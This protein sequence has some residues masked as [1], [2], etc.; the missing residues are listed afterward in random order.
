M[1][2]FAISDIHGCKKTFKALLKKIKLTPTDTLFLLGDYI[3]RGP[4]SRGVIKY[5]LKLKKKG[6]KVHCLR[7]NH[8]QM[9]I[10]ALYGGS[11]EE[12]TQWMLSG[13]AATLKSYY[14]GNRRYVRQKHLTF[15]KK[16]PY[17]IETEGYILVHAGLEFRSPNP[18]ANQRRM[19]WIRS[20]YNNIDMAWLNGRIIV[21]GH[22]PVTQDSIKSSLN[23]LETRPVVDIDCGCVY[24][25]KGMNQ[26][27]AFNLDTQ[28]LIFQENIEKR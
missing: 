10:D 12:Q 15:I 16:L 6:Y 14:K 5:I 20:W 7:G 13:G 3:D 22:T 19:I 1:S 25:R 27:C 4:N 18:F 9:M 8:E 11:E 23:Y 24:T 26:L 17:Y 2:R 21:H 28:E